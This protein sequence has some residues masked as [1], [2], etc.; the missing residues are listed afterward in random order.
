MW[1]ALVFLIALQVSAAPAGANYDESKVPAYTLPDA[2]VMAD[3]RK[4]TDAKTWTE[5]RRPELLKLF[6]TYVYG[7][8]PVGR[9]AHLAWEVVSED[10]NARDGSAI[11]KTSR[12]F[13]TR[14]TGH[15][16]G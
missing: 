9:P 4:V 12:S 8:T 13:L 3:G 7:K 16:H 15:P 1:N 5:K 2:L 10:R 6:E 11:A 14:R